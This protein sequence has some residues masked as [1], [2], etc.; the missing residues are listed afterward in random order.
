[1]RFLEREGI[2]CVVDGRGF[3]CQVVAGVAEEL[4]EDIEVSDVV[5]KGT[6]GVVT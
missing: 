4:A 1:L 2:G 6:G 5:V 3:G